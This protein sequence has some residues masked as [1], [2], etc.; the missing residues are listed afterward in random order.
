MLSVTDLLR[1]R[2]SS[3]GPALIEGA[4]GLGVTWADVDAQADR[5]AAGGPAGPVGLALADPVAMA[6]NFVAALRV[7]TV[8]APLDPAAPRAEHEARIRQLGLRAIVVEPG[9][10]APSGVE[11]WTAGR[12]DLKRIG[13]EAGPLRPL[14]A[15]PAD[16]RAVMASSGTTGA[17]K[18]IPL[19]ESQLLATAR[20]VAGHLALGPE[21]RGYSPLPLFHING[22]VIG[23]L[24][25]LVAGSTIVLERQF[26]RRSFWTTAEQRGATWLNLVPAILA[27]L[28]APSVAGEPRPHQ[29]IR[30]ARSAS[31]PLPA[32]VRDRFE[33]LTGIPV[34]ETYGMT[35]AAS[36]ITANPMVDVRPGSVGLPV[37]VELRVVGPGRLAPPAG[38]TGRVQIRGPRV[39]SWY[40]AA[41]SPERPEWSCREALDAD[42][43]LDTGDIG[44]LDSDGYLYLV[45]RDGDVINRGG[46][47]IQ[48]R[49]VEEVLL[50]DPR[51]TAAVVVPRSH[52]TVGEEPVAYVLATEGALA[53]AEQLTADLRHRCEGSLSRFKRPADIIV[54]RDLPA[55]PTGK[56]RR[57]EVR[58]M[59]RS[60]GPL[61]TCP[62]PT[63]TRP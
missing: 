32:A 52:P 34:V 23:V 33:Q 53:E 39:T 46:E 4:T 3:P 60:P 12:R 44:R 62:A 35:E 50:S 40:W 5:W 49:E 18:I 2:A 6:A 61:S 21:D 20:G 26:S 54:A 56:V 43:W 7:G 51:V 55:G 47:K 31:A 27:I 24:S 29:A 41:G 58:S 59:I 17:P 10:E 42:G 57:A 13:G 19:T 11:V 45:G 30:L 37:D 22:L 8:V 38:E 25:A 63:T 9:V 28:G 15:S 16:V 1:S 36:Q 48:P 14:P